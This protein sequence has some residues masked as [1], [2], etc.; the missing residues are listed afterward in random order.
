MADLHFEQFPR[1]CHGA[2]LPHSS[3][4]D[5]S[6]YVQSCNRDYKN[7]ASAAMYDGR[8]GWCL[9]FHAGYACRHSGA[10]CRAGWAIPFRADEADRVAAL[11]LTGVAPLVRPGRPGTTA[12]APL[13][14]DGT[15]GFFQADGLCAIHR[16]GGHTS[17]PITCQMFPR[18]ALLDARGTFITLSHYCP[19]AASLLFDGAAAA[20]IVAAPETLMRVNRLEGLDAT[21][22]WAPLL[23]DGVLM[24]LESYGAWERYGIR[25]LTSGGAP[26]QALER[27]ERAT[28]RVLDWRPALRDSLLGTIDRAFSSVESSRRTRL[29]DG[30]LWKLVRHA[31]PSKLTPQALPDD[32]KPRLPAAIAA[33]DAHAPAIGRWLAARLFANW[34]AY[35][36]RGLRTILRYL[37]AAL[38][39]VVVELARDAGR[40]L[41]RRD[42]V[43]AI[44]R[45]DY[46]M[47]HLAESQRLATLLS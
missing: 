31:V 2:A 40:P 25:T 35:Q 4:I 20:S 10:C 42:V 12:F 14:A 6:A 44:R 32:L 23:C 46:L 5:W 22:T 21:S 38:D 33:L 17:L 39:V 18:I 43:E 26:W 29:P 30:R 45:S 7:L 1:L 11:R 9:D 3:A 47:V 16:A 8:V 24:D 37:H 28:A 36:G 27:L 15:C 41:A 13:A 19:T 34:I